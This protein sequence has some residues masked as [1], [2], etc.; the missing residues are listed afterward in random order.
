MKKYISILLLISLATSCSKD[1][2]DETTK[3]L[4]RP[5]DYFLTTNDLEKCV[6]ALFSNA[7]L[8]YNQTATMSFCMGGDDVTTLPGGNKEGYKQ[9]DVFNAQDNNDRY[10]NMYT[11]AYGTIKQANVIITN[12][13]KFVEPATNPT[14]LADQKKRALGQAYF[15]RALSY[16]NL[17]RMCNEI[18]LVTDLS[19]SYDVTKSQAADVY[20]LIVEDLTQAETL[21]P[22]K[23]STAPNLSSLEQSTLYARPTS[24]SAK[25]LLASVYLTMAG[26]PVNDNT[27]YAL[28]A[29][30]AKEVIDN[31][32]GY[33]YILMV[34]YADLWKFV[35]NINSETVFGLYYNHVVGDWSDNG[36]WANGNMNCPLSYKPGDF[37]GWDDLF[38]ELTF[39]KEFPSGPR[40]DATF[41]TQAKK[42]PT[43]PVLT[44]QNYSTKHPYYKKW[45]DIPGWDE[46]NAGAYFDWWSSR[47]VM[48]I[49]YAEV[50]LVYAEAKAMSGGADAL[51]YTCVNRVKTR[52]GVPILAG[53]LSATAFRDSI[54]VERKWEFAGNEPNARWFDMIRTETVESA[55]AKRDP[56]ETPLVNQPT[57]A[58]YF[59][60]IPSVDRVLNPNL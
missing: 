18:P 23:F 14:L 9:F 30:K 11:C 1:F 48:V 56:L 53:G 38:A 60:P 51:A 41:L 19:V 22:V 52:A 21:L 54:I 40:K 44:W 47:S 17:V 42:T 46:N 26:Y 57:K 10:V 7:N 39:F 55:T 4:I 24:G 34:N 15:I 50:L 32:A 37:G 33:G 28:A 58:R 31:E 13:D 43:D 29:A 49:R 20:A 36:T 2:L 45:L 25:A 8:M 12:I 59:A 27:K 16:F 35:N 3:G 6:N 5:G